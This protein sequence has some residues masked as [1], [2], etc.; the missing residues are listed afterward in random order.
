MNL[1][2]AAG[3]AAGALSF[4]AFVPYALAT[5]RGRTRPN[6]ATWIIWTAVGV[7]LLASYA[8]A[9]A[10]ETVWVAA[11][12]LAAFLF[13]LALSFKYG[14]GG[15]TPFDSG[16]LIAAAFGGALWWWFDSP[17]P[18]LFSGLFVDLVGALPTIKKAWED[19][20]SEDL[21]AWVLF[22]V[23]NAVNLLAL[24]T[25]SVV[26]ASYPAYMVFITLLLVGILVLRR[27]ATR[28]VTVR[29]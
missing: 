12:N 23:A 19:P 17:L 1:H 6:R 25:W 22:A 18:T 20:D 16:C 21:L 11:A 2:A 8:A 7:S 24:R 13:V 28:R 15:W 26:L 10:R 4:L 14:V 3:I 9:G 27:G 29:T 5:L